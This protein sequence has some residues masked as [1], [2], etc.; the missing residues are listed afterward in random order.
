VVLVVVVSDFI[1]TSIYRSTDQEVVSQLQ[2]HRRFNI[3]QA[4]NECIGFQLKVRQWW[5]TKGSASQVFQQ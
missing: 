5:H 4:G 1:Q 2:L 3:Q